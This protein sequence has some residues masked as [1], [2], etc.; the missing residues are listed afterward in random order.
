[1]EGK[2]IVGRALQLLQHTDTKYLLT[3]KTWTTKIRVDVFTDKILR[4]Q[5][6]DCRVLIE[7]PADELQL[8]GV[9]VVDPGRGEPKLIMVV[10]AHRG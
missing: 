5:H 6:C 1:M 4:H 8:T 3:R 2:L 7:N 9:R 10:S